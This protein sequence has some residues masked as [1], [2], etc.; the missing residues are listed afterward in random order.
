MI[1]FKKEK[2]NSLYAAGLFFILVFVYFILYNQ[3]HFYYLEQIQLFRFKWDYFAGFFT[4]PG[5]FSEYCG[6]YLTQF[7]LIPVIGPVIVTLTAIAIYIVVIKIFKIFNVSGII[8]SFIPVL[9]LVALHSDY[10]YKLGYSVGLLISL[11]FTA[12]CLLIQKSKIRYLAGFMG[13]LILYPLTGLFSFLSLLLLLLNELF[14]GRKKYKYVVVLG[15]LLPM[16]FLPYLFWRYIYILP[17]SEAWLTPFSSSGNIH[18][19]ITLA[20]LLGYFPIIIVITRLISLHQKQQPITLS[21]EMKNLTAGIIVIAILAGLIKV[22]SSDPKTELILKIDYYLQKQD[23]AK[24]VEQCSR[25]QEPNMMITYFTN[26]SLLKSGRLGDEMFHYTQAGEEGLSLPWTNNNLIPFFGCDIYYHLGYFNEAYRW[27]F[28]AMEMNG[29]CPRLLKRL[30]MTSLINGDIKLAEKYLKQL[31]QSLF[32]KKWAEHYLG[33]SSN[34]ELLKLDKEISDKRELIIKNDF[35]AGMDNSQLGLEKLL[36]NHPHNKMAFEYYMA[37]LLLNKD[38]DTFSKEISRLKEF[39]Y[40]EIPIHFEE[41]IL[42]YIGYSKQNIIPKGFNVRKSTLE[43]FKNYI[44]S[45]SRK[46]VSPNVLANSMGKEFGTTFWYYF[47][48]INPQ[49]THQ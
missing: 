42:W 27:A 23:W 10:L 11:A 22:Y 26:L 40:K 18:S 8:W 13:F 21:W 9:M 6:A 5:G 30:I 2:F 47:H 15:Y 19:R 31:Q 4:N 43:R 7:F 25:Y 16:I 46:N 49:K 17:L 45:Y 48:F 3:Y 14:Y 39:G 44:Y 12:I 36:E 20:L 29:M 38:M 28:E 34:P 24:A 41:A 37:M 33:M 32:Y 35:F 1:G